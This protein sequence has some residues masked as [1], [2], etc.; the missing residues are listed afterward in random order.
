MPSG[1][2]GE[3]CARPPCAARFAAR[4]AAADPVRFREGVSSGPRKGERTAAGAF[5][6][7]RAAG[8]GSGA[9]GR[10]DDRGGGHGPGL[11][12]A[13]ERAPRRAGAGSAR[14]PM[15]AGTGM[16]PPADPAAKNARP[17]REPDRART[18]RVAALATA[19]GSTGP[20]P[21]VSHHGA[22]PTTTARS[23]KRPAGG[24]GSAGEHR[25][26]RPTRSSGDPEHG[27]GSACRGAGARA[28]AVP[29]RWRLLPSARRSLGS[30]GRRRG[31]QAQMALSPKGP[32]G[33]RQGG[34]RPSVRAARR[35]RLRSAS[36][37]ADLVRF[38]RRIGNGGSGPR[39]RPCA[40]DGL[41]RGPGRAAFQVSAPMQ[42][43]DRP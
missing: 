41:A 5:E 4:K 42:L 32:R 23:V 28:W 17:R 9:H 43:G 24:S 10:G 3:A 29:A 15:P 26:V 19:A 14:G 33:G 16:P 20:T 22:R 13:A 38:F 31:A 8:G 40:R 21:D 12:G 6:G 35:F 36:P 39:D 30:S 1:S 7:L 2:G 11:H 27:R 18:G 25:D 34:G 37:N